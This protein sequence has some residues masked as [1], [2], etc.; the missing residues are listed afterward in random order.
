MQDA[1]Q[2][3]RLR[4]SISAAQKVFDEIA[5]LTVDGQKSLC[6]YLVRAHRAGLPKEKSGAVFAALRSM[7][8][9]CEATFQAAIAQPEPRVS[10]KSR[11]SLA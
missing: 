11:V 10:L 8:G 9:D 6:T 1:I 2:E 3:E 5:A 4:A 7:V